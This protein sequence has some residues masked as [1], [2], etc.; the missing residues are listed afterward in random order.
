M[1]RKTTILCAIAALTMLAGEAL[2]LS[3]HTRDGWVLGLSFGGARGKATFNSF[4]EDAGGASVSGT[5]ETEDGVSPQMR[6]SHMLGNHLAV[7]ASYT[8]WM[9]E[10]VNAAKPD[11]DPARDKL[12]FSLQNIML[13]LTWYP[14]QAESGWGGLYVRGGVGLAWTAITQVTLVDG[15]E[16][17]HGHRDQETGLGLELNVGYEFRLVRSMA[18]GIGIGINHQNIGKDIYETSTFYPVTLNLGWYWD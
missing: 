4:P 11:F 10:T 2:A 8:G 6:L 15:E 9:Y 7:G 1:P 14:G 13:G 16:Q 18:A 3:P 5:G 12:R 17:G